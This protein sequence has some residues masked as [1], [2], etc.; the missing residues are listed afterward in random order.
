MSKHTRFQRQVATFNSPFSKTL[1]VCL[2]FCL[3]LLATQHPTQAQTQR[4]ST[5]PSGTTIGDGTQAWNRVV[6]LARPRVASGDV[7]A[8][9]SSIRDTVSTFTLC[10]LASVEQDPT[11]APT[12]P[13]YRFADVGAG[14]AMDLDGEMKVVTS[15]GYRDAGAKLG[16]IQRRMLSTNEDQL[17]TVKV[18]LRSPTIWIFDTPALIHSQGQHLDFVLRH[19]VWLD[20]TTGEPATLVW[21]LREKEEGDYAVLK[22]PMRFVAA[23]TKEDRRI[24]VDGGEFTL[25]IPS[26]KAF[27]I[28]GLPPGKDIAWNARAVSLAGRKQFTNTEFR[29]LAVSLN[30]AIRAADQP[31]A[32]TQ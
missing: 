22:N 28:E 14:Y 19:F 24:H 25:G 18:L 26:K 7:D 8:I 17:E 3:A 32:P 16:F 4:L 9:A 1:I 15:A 5:I 21:L 29:D 20:S 23:G 31:P 2:S 12:A 30:E 6:L 10:I 27:A 13:R 11:S